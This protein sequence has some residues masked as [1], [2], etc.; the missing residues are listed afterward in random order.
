MLKNKVFLSGTR[1]LGVTDI[2]V[3]KLLE[4]ARCKKYDLLIT[5]DLLYWLEGS[6]HEPSR[7]DEQIR[8]IDVPANRTLWYAKAVDIGPPAPY[9]DYVFIEGRGAR[10]PT[11]RTMLKR[12]AEKFCKMLLNSPPQKRSVPARTHV[13]SG[14]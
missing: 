13:E 7:A 2:R 8:V 11:A 10:A 9:T 14:E 1:E 12:N 6:L 5:G 4:I 3:E